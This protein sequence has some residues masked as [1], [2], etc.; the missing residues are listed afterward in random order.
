MWTF[1]FQLPLTT[2]RPQLAFAELLAGRSKVQSGVEELSRRIGA[3]QRTWV[4]GSVV[5]PAP[6]AV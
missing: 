6:Q 1:S 3:R 2:R 4:R 5:Q